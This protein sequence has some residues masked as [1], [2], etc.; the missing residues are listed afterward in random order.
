MAGVLQSGDRLC[1][2]GDSITQA[3]PGYTRLAAA[4]LTAVR[5][6][7]A[8]SYV[9]AGVGGNRVG[10]LLDRLER[11]VLG[12]GATVVTV[13]I[14]VNDVWHRRSG[15]SG[16]TQD[17]AFTAGYDTLLSR[18]GQA[19][20]RAV[21]LTPTVIHEE[22]EAVENGELAVL[23]GAQHRLA[24]AHAVCVC[25][26]NAAFTATLAA[27]RRAVARTDWPLGPDGGTRFLTTDGVHL[28]PA[29]NA[30]AAVHVVACLAG[31]PLA[32]SGA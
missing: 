1:F 13:S 2:L 3:D 6:D 17:A 22:A 31:W 18:L 11:D 30:L 24:A 32:G 19:G 14:G 9:Y 7:L 8:L 28:N 27:R 12:S 23:V 21:V 16:G 20:I 26:L 15:A 10:D 25:D 29:G 5:P 4:L